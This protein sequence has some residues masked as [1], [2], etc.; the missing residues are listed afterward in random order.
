MLIRFCIIFSLLLFYIFLNFLIK[1][2]YSLFFYW[3]DKKH[4]GT[5]DNE[6]KY[7]SFLKQNIPH[8]EI[9]NIDITKLKKKKELKISFNSLFEYSI[10]QFKI[11]I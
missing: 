11:F 10:Q 7:F 3:K 9:T 8:F 2:L 1:Y 6:Y 5:K 4:K